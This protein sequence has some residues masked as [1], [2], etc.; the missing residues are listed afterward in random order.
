MINKL[1]QWGKVIK[2]AQLPTTLIS[3]FL[4]KKEFIKGIKQS[5]YCP[6]YIRSI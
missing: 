6:I 1:Y 3:P 4:S 2:T 5:K